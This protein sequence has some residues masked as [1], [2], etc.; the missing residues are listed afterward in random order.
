MDFVTNTA[1]AHVFALGR[2]IAVRTSA[3]ATLR[4]AWLP[5]TW[6]LPIPAG[7]LG[8]G[9]GAL[10]GAGLLVLLARAGAGAALAR[11]PVR[12]AGAWLLALT[13]LPPNAWAGGG[14]PQ[15]G[16]GGNT[17]ARRWITHDHLG[18]AILYTDASGAVVHRRVFE[19]FGMIAAETPPTEPTERL[20]TGQRFEDEAG[21]YNF[22]ARWYDAE[23]GRF[24]SVDPILQ[25]MG[26]PQTHNGY[27]YVR[28]DPV[29]LVDPT[30]A[31]F[32]LE[33]VAA[34]VA[35]I[36]Q[37]A[38]L[39][40]VLYNA[41]LIYNQTPLGELTG[42]GPSGDVS[43]TEILLGDSVVLAQVNAPPEQPGGV[44]N[45]TPESTASRAD[46]VSYTHTLEE[47]GRI[48]DAEDLPVERVEF[49][50][51]EMAFSAWSLVQIGRSLARA[52]AEG[53]ARGAAQTGAREA[54]KISSKIERQM[55]RRR[56]MPQQIDEAVQSGKQVRAINRATGNPATRY[57]HPE[58]GQ[59]VVVDNVTGEVIHVGGPG[60]RY[61]PGSGDLP[62]P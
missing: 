57:V 60:F 5:A 41:L 46:S 54:L 10:A 51:V 36:L 18:N 26:D 42:N 15:F 13:F 30:G 33:I 62:L 45:E 7:P 6:P 9:V 43:A 35:A 61:G 14:P 3:N 50:P 34:V 11:R 39:G 53:A 44:G 31:F 48:L 17:W 27:G 22:R 29:N 37:A 23:T 8:W 19:P 47:Y 12:T 20:F 1:T 25:D 38:F 32:G 21:V 58:T 2:E 16:N 24:L 55:A 59:S 4:E 49:G 28:N 52:A 56:W 40:T